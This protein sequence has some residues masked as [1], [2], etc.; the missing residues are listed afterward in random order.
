MLIKKIGNSKA[1]KKYFLFTNILFFVLAITI[2]EILILFVKLINNNCSLPNIANQIYQQIGIYLFVLFLLL[3]ICFIHW[4]VKFILKLWKSRRYDL[5]LTI[6][7]GLVLFLYHNIGEF[8]NVANLYN[9]I[10]YN[11]SFLLIFS[12]IS[13]SV[14]PIILN[15]LDDLKARNEKREKVKPTLLRDDPLDSDGKDLFGYRELAKRFSNL[16]LKN[17]SDKGSLVFGVEAPWGTGKTT[18]LNMFEAEWNIIDKNE[19]VLIKF[20]PWHFDSSSEL[21]KKFFGELK[22]AI[23]KKY[24]L[25][26]INKYLKDYLNIIRSIEFSQLSIGISTIPES[27]DK[28]HSDISEV[29]RL[30]RIR[31]IVIIDDLDRSPLEMSKQIFRL[32]SICANFPYL[33]YIVCYDP[34]NLI[35]ADILTTKSRTEGNIEINQHPKKLSLKQSQEIDSSNIQ[36][37]LEKIV[38]VKY[39]LPYYKKDVIIDFLDQKFYELII[40]NEYADLPEKSLQVQQKFRNA[41]ERIFNEVPF[42]THKYINTIRHVKNILNTFISI[43]EENRRFSVYDIGKIEVLILLILLKYHYPK[44]YSDI[45]YYEV[46]RKS[47]FIASKPKYF[48]TPLMILSDD[49]KHGYREYLND[50]SFDITLT[51]IFEMLFYDNKQLLTNGQLLQYIKFI[52]GIDIDELTDSVF[53]EFFSSYKCHDQPD[54]NQVDGYRKYVHDMFNLEYNQP[55]DI[56]L[57]EMFR[58]TI[59][60]LFVLDENSVQSLVFKDVLMNQFFKKVSDKIQDVNRIDD[61][62]SQVLLEDMLENMPKYSHYPPYDHLSLNIVNNR[63]SM[64]LAI[65]KILENGIWN[66]KGGGRNFIDNVKIISQYILGDTNSGIESILSKLGH[67][68][69]AL[70]IYDMVITHDLCVDLDMFN[71]GRSLAWHRITQNGSLTGI[72]DE[73]INNRTI[74]ETIEEICIKTFE[75]FKD[76]YI[77]PNKN[78]FLDVKNL[79]LSDCLGKYVEK[80]QEWLNLITNEAGCS[81]VLEILKSKI[82]GFVINTLCIDDASYKHCGIFEYEG[83]KIKSIMQDYLFD[84]CF[85]IKGTDK[86]GFE[87][88]IRFIM[89]QYVTSSAGASLSFY[90]DFEKVLKVLDREKLDKYWKA[91]GDQIK[92]YFEGEKGYVRTANYTASYDGDLTNTNGTGIF[93]ILDKEF[94]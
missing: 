28:T 18:F 85:S 21:M 24:Y 62:F 44:V 57:T 66:S 41:I 68:R 90:L 51:T 12:I 29:L 53:F 58:E 55:A 80:D 1:M 13:A 70:G 89:K 48:F 86:S 71:I 26:E 25:P 92:E 83:R 3:L 79:S 94:S 78:F 30:F 49:T 65:T 8:E 50:N 6:F 27:L 59:N 9:I 36:R 5:L 76:E 64:S 7:A 40:R 22:K 69:G 33:N 35:G 46:D 32:V 11:L 47:S 15:Y 93:D 61:H 56:Y 77:K 2:G 73:R 87:Y 60:Q 20:D 37:Y 10:R 43:K 54:L 81:N 52:E 39:I 38:N 42:I 4:L 82:E 75:V 72:T 31:L 19:S 84:F 23:N 67:S 74:K 16:I 91:Y 45:C 88:F 17:Y 14:V 34:D 63:F